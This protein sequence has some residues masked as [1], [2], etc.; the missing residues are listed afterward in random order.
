MNDAVRIPTGHP[1]ADACLKGGLL[2]GALHE[3]FA[4]EPGC[5]TSA[6]GFAIG[7][8]AR[9]AKGKPFLWIGQDFVA[10][11]H[12]E[13]SATGFHEM[14]VDPARTLLLRVCDMVEALKAA[15]DALSCAALG[16]VVIET[17]GMSKILDLATSRRLMLAAA[18]K[19]VSVFLLRLGASAQP[20]AAETRWLIR[21]ARSFSKK[22]DCSKKE[23][24]GFASF[25]AALARNRHGPVG[26][27][28]MEW[29][30]DA[31]VFAAPNATSDSGV[32]V[33][34]SADGSPPAA[35]QKIAER[36]A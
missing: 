29:N 17:M 9:M 24:W 28:V 7:L 34:L 13:L 18:R 26:Y 22:E 1:Q 8:A 21:P 3:I 4:A 10:L 33:S 30:S 11:E 6:S 2:K 32:V 14:G 23:D 15:G 5:E 16:A 27:W 31:C 36:A 25:A 12:G 19:G 35:D 20:S